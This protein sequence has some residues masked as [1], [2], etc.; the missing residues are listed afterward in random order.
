MLISTVR[1]TSVP[2]LELDLVLLRLADGLQNKAIAEQLGISIRTVENH[3]AR[4]MEKLNA[5]T[6]ADAVRIAIAL[7]VVDWQPLANSG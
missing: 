4:V 2:N 3:R 5:K 6:V 1:M 7:R